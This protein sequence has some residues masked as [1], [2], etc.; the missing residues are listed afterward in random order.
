MGKE[1]KVNRCNAIKAYIFLYFMMVV[2][3]TFGMLNS[4]FIAANVAWMIPV[5][6]FV[7]WLSSYYMIGFE[8]LKTWWSE[9]IRD[10]K[11]RYEFRQQVEKEVA[12]RIEM[13]RNV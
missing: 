3:M 5:N 7:L 10:A 12:R 11:K 9:Y 2:F 1:R 8:S 6:A 13:Q 4:P